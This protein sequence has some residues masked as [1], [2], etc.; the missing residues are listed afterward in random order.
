MARDRSDVVAGGRRPETGY[1]DSINDER[2]S[3]ATKVLRATGNF[4]KRRW[5]AIQQEEA[6]GF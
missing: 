5:F 2:A 4:G 3:A 1:W 6:H